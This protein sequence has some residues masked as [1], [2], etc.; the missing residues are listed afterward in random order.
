MLHHSVPPPASLTA[1][2]TVD[3]LTLIDLATAETDVPAAN[4]LLVRSLAEKMSEEL[5]SYTANL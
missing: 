3:L 4:R 1:L 5:W 2:D